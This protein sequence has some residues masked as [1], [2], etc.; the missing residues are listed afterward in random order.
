M[1]LKAD[2]KPIEMDTDFP[3]SLYQRYVQAAVVRSAASFIMWLTAL[4]VYFFGI[5][6]TNNFVSCQ[7][8]RFIPHPGEPAYPLG[9]EK[10]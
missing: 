3:K 8:C 10:N 5:I 6:H 7:R 1:T 4:M 2:Q 9:S